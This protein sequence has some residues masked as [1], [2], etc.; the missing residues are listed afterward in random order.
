MFNAELIKDYLITVGADVSSVAVEE[1]VAEG[2]KLS[3]LTPSERLKLIG[4]RLDLRNVTIGQTS[5]DRAPEHAFPGL[6]FMDLRWV[7]VMPGANGVFRALKRI[8]YSG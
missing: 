7:M 4:E 6:A 5:V 2:N 1:S 8:R 3:T